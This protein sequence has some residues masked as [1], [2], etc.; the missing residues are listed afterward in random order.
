MKKILVLFLA[1]SSLTVAQSFEYSE[2]IGKFNRASSFYITANGLIYVSDSGSDEIIL[3]DTLGNQMNTFGG[4]GWDENS[5]DDP[6]DVF[7]D[8][9]SIYVAD[10][11]NHKIKRFDKNLNFIS[12]LYRRE[13]E[14]LQEQFGYPLSCATSNQGDLYFIDSENKRIMKFDIF[15]NFILNF[16]GFDAGKYQLTNPKQLAI[17]SWNY[18]FVIDGSDI[19]I[20]DNFGNGTN[21]ISI[22]KPVN[23]IRILFD[24]MIICNG[25]E[26]Y[27]SYL[28]SIDSKFTKIDL[29]G[30]EIDQKIISGILLNNRLYILT[31]KKLLVFDQNN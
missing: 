9:L 18:I 14:F 30:F 4:Y 24:H 2:S 20:F 15:G 31:A 26:V 29:A 12:S 5:F 23:S 3:L 22:D 27:H 16:G 10:N 1:I 11:N 17:S 8:P 6:A 21:R 28:K 25:E 19:V 13:S 7:A